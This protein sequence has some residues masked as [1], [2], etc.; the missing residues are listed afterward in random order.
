[1]KLLPLKQH[2]DFPGMNIL[3]FSLMIDENEEIKFTCDHN[4][5]IY[6]GTHDNNTI[7]GWLSQDLPEAKKTQIIKYLRTKVR[8]TVQR[9]IFY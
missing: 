7:S 3:Q 1:M 2:F 8:K 9:V 5:I 4:S 6:T